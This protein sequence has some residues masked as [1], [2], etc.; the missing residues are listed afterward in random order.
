MSNFDWCVYTYKH[1]KM[2]LYV[3]D[4]YIKDPRIKEEMLARAKIHDMDKMLMYLFMEQVETQMWHVSNKSHHLESGK[5]HTYLDRLEMVL[6]YESAPYTKPDKPLN[7]YDFTKKL[8]DEG[9]IAETEAEPLFE[10]MHDLGIDYSY[11]ATKDKEGMDFVAS[12]GEVTWEMILME[13]LKYVNEN[14]TNELSIVENM[15]KRGEN[16]HE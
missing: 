10:I 16:S 12:I 11:D 1:R 13:V 7:A 9:Y 4:K 15:L 5:V 6:D 8:C 2:L 14:R 3:I